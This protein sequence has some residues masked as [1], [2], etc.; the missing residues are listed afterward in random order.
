MLKLGNALMC[1]AFR[2]PRQLGK[3]ML[4][5]PG[6]LRD[7]FHILVRQAIRTFTVDKVEAENGIEPLSLCR[8]IDDRKGPARM[9]MKSIATTNS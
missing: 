6:L 1:E 5:S 2:T 7:L 3:Q 4:L 9:N 8:T